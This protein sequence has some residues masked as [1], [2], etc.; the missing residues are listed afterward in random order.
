M[1]VPKFQVGDKIITFQDDVGWIEEVKTVA[2]TTTLYW[3]NCTTYGD[4][5]TEGSI[6]YPTPL[7]ELL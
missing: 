7:D 3:C 2:D 5:F 4:W 6:R 1:S